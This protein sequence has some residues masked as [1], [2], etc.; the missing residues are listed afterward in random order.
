MGV[1]FAHP[2]ALA[3]LAL[4]PLVIW[5]WRRRPRPAIAW[6]GAAELVPLAACRAS[7]ITT[8]LLSLALVCSVTALANPRRPVPGERLEAEGIAVLLVID[9]SGS[10]AEPDFDWHGDAVPRLEAVRRAF[11]DFVH[12][13]PQDR[14][15]LVLFATHPETACP[16]TLDHE[17]LTRLLDAASPRGLPTESETNLG[18]AVAWGLARLRD[19]PGRKVMVV[20]S[21][22]EHNVPAPAL[23]PRQA[24]QLAAAA[25][26][27][28]YAIFAGP[29]GGPGWSGLDAMARMTG[30]AAFA[31]SDASALEQAG[32][33]IDRLERETVTDVRRRRYSEAYPLLA[34]AAA[35]CLGLVAALHRGPWL[36]IP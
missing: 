33:A 35:G 21:D 28:V 1:D 27:P 3:L 8:T 14:L 23:T 5:L 30:G 17:A 4:V 31:A 11:R 13:R 20:C 24:G 36:T 7:L 9:V 29:A 12:R 25:E 2:W 10:M 32:R 18:D 19:T 15:G 34:L 22:G 6:P 26:V 16:L